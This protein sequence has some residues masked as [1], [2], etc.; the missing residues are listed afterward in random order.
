[1]TESND[2][3]ALDEDFNL[4]SIGIPFTNLQWNRRYYTAGEFQLQLSSKV[5]DPSWRY[6]GRPDRD[7]LGMVQAQQITG[8]ADVDVLLSG[9]FCEKMLDDKSC[10]PRYIGDVPKTETAVRDIFS[11]YKKD[12]PIELAPANE[13]LL[14]DRTQSDFSDDLLG[15][16]LYSILESRECSYRVRYDYKTSKLLFEVWQ[17]LNRTQSQNVNS[18]QTFSTEF[19]N[20]THWEI[21]LDE[22]A[23]RNYAIIPCNSDD[24]GKEQSIFYVDLSN[25]GYKKEVTFDMRSMKPEEGQT[26]AAFKE[27]IEQEGLEKLLSYSKI[28]DISVQQAGN[29]GY[30]KDFDLGD[31][32]DCIITDAGLMMET[33]IV[34]CL[35]VI[36][37]DGGLSVDIGLGNK[38]IDN[39]RRAVNAL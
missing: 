23:Y 6:I 18:Q 38:R 13:V 29:I 33:R 20:L 32:C 1:M 34:E 26:M 19:G 8:E 39:I 10:F 3:Y 22:S 28:E 11:Q 25:G 16:K 27:A 9:Y 4:V 2:I 15:T 36:K 35:E 14:G 37:A 24:E 12:L 5:F 31:R 30:R 7:E 21:D 17:G